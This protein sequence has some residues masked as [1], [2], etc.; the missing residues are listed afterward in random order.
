MIARRA[1][2]SVLVGGLV[3]SS[4]CFTYAAAP[5]TA[6]LTEQRAEFRIS[7]EGRVALRSQLGVGVR[8][9]EGRVASQSESDW[10][11]RV[12]R[13]T[14]LDG[15]ASVWS[16]ETVG[17]PRTAV[18]AVMRRDFDRQRSTV[19]AA[20][21]AG[22]VVLFVLSRSLLGGG[23]LFGPSGPGPIAVDIRQ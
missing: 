4:A 22:A 2:A 21:T 12:Y 19:A 13:I 6:V 10:T 9:I 11:V 15:S 14:L 17:V 20:G 8:T 16:G 18:D 3:F 5:E 7:D 23:S 1:L